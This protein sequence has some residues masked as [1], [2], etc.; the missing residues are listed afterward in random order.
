MIKT[1]R[2]SNGKL[3]QFEPE[4]LNKWAS[5]ADKRGII[6]SEV[7]M[8]AMKRVYEGCTTKEMHQAMIDVCIDKQ[9]QEYSDMAGRLLLGIIYKEAF[10]GFT[11]VPNLYVFVNNME[12]L[13]LW[14][15]MDYS[16]EELEYLQGFIVH[17][18]DISYGYAVLKQFRDKYGIRDFMDSLLCIFISLFRKKLD[19]CNIRIVEESKLGVNPFCHDVKLML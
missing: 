7:T 4:R 15:K 3:V 17:S 14:E 10:G 11:K 1:I 2:K 19:S 13:G 12:V 16:R 5:W 9:S 6:W 8:E 18:K